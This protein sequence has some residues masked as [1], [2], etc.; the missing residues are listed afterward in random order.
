MKL[1]SSVCLGFHCIL[2]GGV[3]GACATLAYPTGIPELSAFSHN[4]FLRSSEFPV[5]LSCSDCLA[6]CDWICQA[7]K[8]CFEPQGG[9]GGCQ[10]SIMMSVVTE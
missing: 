2:P 9:L 1:A 8:M 6:C 3:V 5:Q 4:Q 7:A 10:V